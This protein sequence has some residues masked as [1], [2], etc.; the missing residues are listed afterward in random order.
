MTLL[1]GSF[2]R[3]CPTAQ[4]QQ[5]D[6]K[7]AAARLRRQ[8]THYGPRTLL[9][10]HFDSF[11]EVDCS[12]CHQGPGRE[13]GAGPTGSNRE[14]KK[15]LEACNHAVK[16]GKG[17]TWDITGD[18][19]LGG[20]DPAAGLSILSILSLRDWLSDYSDKLHVA[21]SAAASLGLRTGGVQ[22]AV[23]AVGGTG[24]PVAP[25]RPGCV[26]CRPYSP[27]PDGFSRATTEYRDFTTYLWSMWF[28]KLTYFTN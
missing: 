18:Y 17:V 19:S 13:E 16:R 15:H 10:W 22:A 8:C 12:P 26:T 7:R 2:G 20:R 27:L 4:R 21:L 23:A 1:F 11:H 5:F 24:P 9:P 3:V 14:A 6:L 28:L 25:L